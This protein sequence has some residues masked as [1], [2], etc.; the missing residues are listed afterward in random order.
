MSNEIINKNALTTFVKNTLD[1]EI[2]S[3]WE[4]FVKYMKDFRTHIF[5]GGVVVSGVGLF[6]SLYSLGKLQNSKYQFPL[7]LSGIITT[8]LG[9][10]IAVDMSAHLYYG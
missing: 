10:G 3:S 8:I 5:W 2:A 9:T 6:T 7:V 4:D 1:P